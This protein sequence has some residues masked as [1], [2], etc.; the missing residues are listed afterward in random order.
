MDSGLGVDRYCGLCSDI[1][2]LCAESCGLGVDR[3]CGLC[4]YMHRGHCAE[5]SG[6]GADR[7]SSPPAER[8]NGFALRSIDYVDEVFCIC[9]GHA[10][11]LRNLN[12]ALHG[13][14]GL[15]RECGHYSGLG[16]VSRCLFGVV[17]SVDYSRKKRGPIIYIHVIEKSCYQFLVLVKKSTIYYICI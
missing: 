3:C 9:K 8:R 10:P 15:V 13:C 11:A 4:T 12:E 1:S 14:G 16:W 6:L 5:I 2:D 7:I 17:C